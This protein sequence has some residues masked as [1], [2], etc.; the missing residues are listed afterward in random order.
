MAMQRSG[1]SF[2]YGSVSAYIDASDFSE[3]VQMCRN[4]M[5]QD[6]YYKL[7][8][9]TF[10]EIGR[11]LQTPIAREIQKSYVVTQDWVKNQMGAPKISPMEIRI[12]LKGKKGS[13]GGRFRARARKNGRVSS[14]IVKSGVSVLPTAM[15][16]QGGNPPFMVNG[17]C[18][19]RRTAARL[20]IVS[21]KG[22][23]VPQM[24]LNQAADDVQDQI[25]DIAG[26]R[27]MHN[28]DH[29]FG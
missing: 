18:F 28:L 3:K 14:N 29:M 2:I 1:N 20:P 27:L 9:R 25:L 23:A 13:I 7:I 19:T 15:Q 4:V 16:N 22:L 17:V 10:N 26:K 5:S 11:R 21:V 8:N 12:P 6:N 24:P